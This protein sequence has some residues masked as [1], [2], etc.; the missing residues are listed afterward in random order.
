LRPIRTYLLFVVLG[1]TVPPALLTAVLV[2]RAFTTSRTASERRLLESARVDA[3][4]VDRQLESVVGTL[5]ALATAEALDRQDLEQFY[6]QARRVQ[7]T[8]N[9]WF[10]LTLLSI[11]GR[12]LVNTRFPWGTSLLE[13]ADPESFQKVVRTH[14]PA[15]GGIRLPQRSGTDHIFAVR[16]PVMR[17]GQLKFVLSAVLRV[18]ALAGVLPRAGSESEEWTRTILDP[19]GT[20]A[21]RTRGSEDYVGNRATAPFLERL[22]R[23][24]E[25][26]SSETTREGGRVYAATG[27]GAY[28]WSTIVV[29]P[30]VVLDGPL[31]ASMAGVAIGGVLLTLGGFIAVLLASRRLTEDLDAAAVAAAAVVEGR[32]GEPRRA[33]T[34]ETLRLQQSIATAAA[35]L[36]RRAL[37]RDE[38]LRRADAARAEAEEANRTK[39]QFLA[40]LGHELRNPLAPALTALELM[41]VRDPHAF[42]REREVLERQVAHMSRL[43]SD[44]MDIS[45]LSRGKVQL[46]CERIEMRQ[47]IDRAVDVATPLIARQHHELSVDVPAEGLPVDAD[48]DRLVQVFTNLLT[49]AANYTPA[50]GHIRISATPSAGSARI[51]VEDDGP[52]IPAEMVGSLFQPF[53]QGPRAIDRRQGG[54]GLGLALAR[55]FVELHGGE[56]KFES[57]GEPGSRFVITLPLARPQTTTESP[58]APSPREYLTRKV[59]VVDDNRDAAEMLGEALQEAGHSVALASDGMG[60]LKVLATFS[61][62][63]GVFDIGLPGITGY[64]LARRAREAVPSIR[65]IAVTGYGQTSDVDQAMAAGF[66]AHCAKP[67]STSVLLG[68]VSQQDRPRPQT[69][70]APNPEPQS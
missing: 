42:R 29:V 1:A 60:A 55:T 57:L 4:A 45:R 65:L 28:G 70:G 49:N 48:L 53:A 21:V 66:D 34:E 13:V 43:V 9:E 5:Q 15:V 51:V 37:E 61:P 14:Q 27:R 52:G 41:R 68:L 23:D 67:V 56:I 47:A 10:T 38:Q 32:F 12:Q 11:D 17:S 8:Q 7:A 58:A 33:H 3:L 50:G 31:R 39:D 2:A 30:R 26:V 35:L 19:Q 6:E 25:A 63:V 54:L 20:I 22:A 24:P 59:L 69:V 40:V 62:D 64:E 18:E 16:V 36:E 46:T 44:L